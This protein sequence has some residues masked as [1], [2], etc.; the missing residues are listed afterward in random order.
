MDRIKK[1]F[2]DESGSAEA[3]SVA[4]MI[5]ALSSGLTGLWNVM[6]INYTSIILAIV[7]GLFLFWLVFKH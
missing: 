3:V 7:G 6:A 4:V 2:E 5:G 1:L